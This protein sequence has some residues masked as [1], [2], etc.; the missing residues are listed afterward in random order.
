MSDRSVKCFS[1]VFR[2]L[3]ASKPTGLLV[4]NS[5]PRPRYVTSW[6]R[7]LG[8]EPRNL[9]SDPSSGDSDPQQNYR[10]TCNERGRG[11][12]GELLGVVGSVR[13]R[14]AGPRSEVSADHQL[15]PFLF[16]S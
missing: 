10:S 1:K 4:K 5:N 7:S 14:E 8:M 15:T 6:I 2:G 13:G 12:G 9:H 11:R 3:S 16:L